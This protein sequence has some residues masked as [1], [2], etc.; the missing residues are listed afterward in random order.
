MPRTIFAAT[1][2]H[3]GC[4]VA[5]IILHVLCADM[6]DIS[7]VIKVLCTQSLTGL[8]PAESIGPATMRSAFA[9]I[10]DGGVADLELGALMSVAAVLRTQR[11]AQPFAELV[12][13]L[14]EA[15]RERQLPLHLAQSSAPVV[16]LPNYGDDGCAA[17]IPLLAL[18]LRG[19]GVRVLIHGALETHGGLFTCGIMRE[20]DVLP[21]TTR[22]QAEWQ[23]CERGIALV[24]ATLFSPGLAAMLSLRNRLG[25]ATPAHVL[26]KLML[27]LISSSEPV[28][29]VVEVPAWL[30]SHIEN[31]NLLA[32]ARVLL[33]AESQ[34]RL[35]TEGCRPHIAYRDGGGSWQVLFEAACAPAPGDARTGRGLP[36][37]GDPR[38]WAR[39]TRTH[40]SGESILP[41]TIVNL[42]AC[43][44][45]GCGYAGDI[46]HAKAVAAVE[47]SNLAAA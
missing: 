46:N 35:L 11:A 18:L 40:L 8:A 14:H 42:L 10:L 4:L 22:R 30:K 27:P 19:L 2:W 21:A 26:A 39:W 5:C 20:F 34:E 6:S 9:A 41:A 43:C 28:L 12:L 29:H 24:P 32:D 37:E 36:R 45:Y 38:G 44:L 31:E 17:T 15:V 1:G 47:A 25:I 16:A 13:G 7:Q 23:L 3:G 33:L